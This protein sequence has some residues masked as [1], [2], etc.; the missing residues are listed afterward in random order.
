M[1]LYDFRCPEGTVFESTF[2]M[3]DVP[4]ALECPE[5]RQPARRQ[6]SAPRLSIANTAAYK[7]VDSTKRSAHEPAVVSGLPGAAKKPTRYTSNPL[8]QKLPRP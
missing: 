7:L 1:P 8:H 3:M 2:P 5:C 4:D 6:M